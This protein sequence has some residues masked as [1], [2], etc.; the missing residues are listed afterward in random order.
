MRCTAWRVMRA[1]RAFRNTAGEPLPFRESSARKPPY[2]YAFSA[3]SA[4]PE[5]GT[6][7]SRE[8]LP[9]TR[10]TPPSKSMQ[11]ISR[12]TSSL[13]RKPQPYRISSIA[14]LRC[15]RGPSP[16]GWSSNALIWATESAS[17]KR[18]GFLGREI[19][20]AG[21][22]CTSSSETRKRW[23]PFTAETRREIVDAAYPRST[24]S[25]S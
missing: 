11:P 25:D 3:I 9:S 21:F 6:K 22:V 7:R 17:G 4:V 15:A 2:A 20:S 5:I 14:L 12:L 1:P 13:A 10:T 19:D 8:P 16:K 18:S 24:K 23:K